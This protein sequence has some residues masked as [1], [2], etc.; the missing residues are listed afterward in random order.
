MPSFIYLLL[1]I[2]FWS[3][4]YVLGRFTVSAGIDPYSISFLRW[5]LACLIL[6]PF[7]YKK[8]WLE[9]HIICQHWPLLTLFGFL[10]ICNYSLFLYLGLASTTVTNAVLLNSV[11]PVMILIVARLLIGTKTTWLQNLGIII[12]TFGAIVIVSRGSLDTFLHLTVSQG[13]LWI[14]FAALSWA[15]YSVLIT[16]RPKEMSLISYFACT[17][18]IGTIIQFPLFLL[19]GHN[20]LADF[21]VANWGTIIYMAVFSSIGA[22]LCWNIG[23]QKLGTATAGQFIHLMPVFSI[24]LSVLFLGEI[25]F[26]FHYVGIALIFSGIFVATFLNNRQ[27]SR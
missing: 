25:L 2:L 1:P 22:F 11:L 16:K 27:K 7:A 18:I 12:S 23:I 21:T 5:S 20:L 4:N 9:R 6:L 19:F 17:A 24:V 13:D 14:I 26:S 10:G 15:I 3:G 8:L